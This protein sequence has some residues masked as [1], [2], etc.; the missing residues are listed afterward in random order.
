M[1][2]H[3]EEPESSGESDDDLH[4]EELHYLDN[5]D[6]EQVMLVEESIPEDEDKRQAD[7]VR[8]HDWLLELQEDLFEKDSLD[9]VDYHV[10]S[11]EVLREGEGQSNMSVTEPTDYRCD[12]RQDDELMAFEQVDPSMP[13]KSCWRPR[14]R[15]R[16]DSSESETS[17]DSIL[18]SP[19]NG[20]SGSPG[21]QYRAPMSTVPV[22]SYYVTS[23]VPF[24]MDPT[25]SEHV[26]IPPMPTSPRHSW[27][28]QA[29]YS[30]EEHQPVTTGAADSHHQRSHPRGQSTTYSTMT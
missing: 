26:E 28:M 19:G 30:F 8:E 10:T 15:E 2:R 9:D 7:A 20:G 17:A 6:E 1:I 16:Y 4:D 11:S 3:H 18:A 5:D 27:G 23:G 12:D 13:M 21:G 24:T 14:S 25:T 29:N 22:T